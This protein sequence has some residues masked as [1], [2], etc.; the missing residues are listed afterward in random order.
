MTDRETALKGRIAL[1]L[2]GLSAGIAAWLVIE[3]LPDRMADAP[4]FYLFLASLAAA[5]FTAALALTGPLSSARALVASFVLALPLSGLMT[6]ASLR[7]GEVGEYLESGHPQVAFA[8]LWFVPL[9][10]VISR[11]GPSRRWSDYDI[12]FNQSW[13]IVVRFA[14]AWLFVGLVWGVLFLSNALLELVGLDVI[15]RL[16][17]RQEAPFLL[18]G[19]TLGVAL[20]VVGELS[21]YV[22]PYLVLRLLRLV[23][24]VVLVVVGVFLA[25]LPFQG[26]SNLFGDFSAAAILM[27]IAIG[28]AG[29]VSV[30]LDSDESRRVQ[31]GTMCWACRAMAVLLPALAIL[32]G[33]AVRERVGQYGLS[34]DRVIAM[35]VGVVVLGYGLAYAGAVLAGQ[36]WA[37]RI[38]R[39]NI[40]MA[41]FAMAI[42]AAFFTPVL[43]PQAMAANSQVARFASGQVGPEAMDLW[44]LAHEWGKPGQAAIARLATM[45]SHPEAEAMTRRL[46][47]LESADSRHTF[48]F[49]GAPD[50]AA[51]LKSDLARRLPV[52]PEGA[53]LPAGLLDSL[54]LWELQQ[55]SRACDYKTAAGYPGCVAMLADLS[56][57]RPGDEVLIMAHGATG[58][59]LVRAYFLD[60]GGQGYTMRSPDYIEGGDFHR[61]ADNAIDALRSGAFAIRPMQLNALEVEGRRLFFG[62]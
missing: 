16:I 46:N 30:V 18:S 20:A 26:L 4:R 10:F 23:L 32:A 60:A 31:G 59:A 27:S 8:L 57:A 51:M 7:F 13:M 17:E 25:A 5:F 49:Q 2:M 40:G 3:V 21:D 45:R 47:A 42:A 12:L 29:L 56:G 53:V 50:D 35:A 24:P 19:L 43:N 41:V 34:P 37:E 11:L 38:R 52:L 48:E 55:I 6:W 14:A 22:S 33:I 1:G 61:D 15:E 28:A 62:R 39:A 9:P 44:S 58:G 36:G 54:R